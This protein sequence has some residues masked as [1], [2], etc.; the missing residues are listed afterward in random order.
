VLTLA[1]EYTEEKLLL[2]RPFLQE[3]RA[4][5]FR[6]QEEANEIEEKLRYKEIRPE[7]R[8]LFERRLAEIKRRLKP[9]VYHRV[10]RDDRS[11]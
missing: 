10:R 4:Q 1:G 7:M 9:P 6:D 11:L 5:A 8:A 3:R 2:W